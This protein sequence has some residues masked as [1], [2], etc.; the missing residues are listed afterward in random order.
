MP[1]VAESLCQRCGST[2]RETLDA[3]PVSTLGRCE[4]G[5]TRQVVRIFPERRKAAQE[6]ARERRQKAV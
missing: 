5:G 1:E 2:S 6:I 4:C 3:R